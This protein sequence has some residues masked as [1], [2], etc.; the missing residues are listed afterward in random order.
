MFKSGHP[1]SY[2]RRAGGLGHRMSKGERLNG[3]TEG[4]RVNREDSFPPPLV[5]GAL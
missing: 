2:V 3:D 4:L 1:T 5:L